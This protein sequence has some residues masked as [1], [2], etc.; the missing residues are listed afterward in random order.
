MHILKGSIGQILFY[1]LG[2]KDMY[3]ILISVFIF[4]IFFIYNSIKEGDSIFKDMF[5][6][7]I[8]LSI[9]LLIMFKFIF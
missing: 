7:F 8:F 3:I 2:G 5:N 4:C 9:L 1:L 6:T